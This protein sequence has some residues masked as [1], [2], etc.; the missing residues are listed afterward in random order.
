MREAFVELIVDIA[1]HQQGD[2]GADSG[3]VELGGHPAQTLVHCLRVQLFVELVVDRVNDVLKVRVDLGSILVGGRRCGTGHAPNV[4][5]GEQ[6]GV[7]PES[8]R[9]LSDISPARQRKFYRQS[10]NLVRV[11]ALI[12]A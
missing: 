11:H 3:L 10:W 12:S 5:P 2:E 8:K 7:T 9:R 1:P 6:V 4:V